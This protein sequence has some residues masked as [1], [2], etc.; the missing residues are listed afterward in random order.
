[1]N[2][3]YLKAAVVF[4]FMAMNSFGFSALAEEKTEEKVVKESENAAIVNGVVIS[5]SEFDR[6]L[7]QYQQRFTMQGQMLDGDQLEE[8]KDTILDT[9]IGRELLFQE[10]KKIN[11]KIE[12]QA[13]EDELSNM[14]KMFPDETAF[15]AALS[16]MGFSEQTIKSQIEKGLMVQKLVDKEYSEKIIISDKESKEFFDTHPEMFRQPEQV[17]ASHIL[18]KTDAGADK[19]QKDAAHKKIQSVQKQVKEGKEFADLAKEFS[20]CPS[21]DQGGDLGYFKRGDM[22]KPFEDAAFATDPGVVTDIVE[23]NFGYHLIKVTDKKTE[24]TMPFDSVKEKLNQYLKNEK[25]Q[26]E[27]DEYVK[28]LKAKAAIEKLI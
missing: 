19:E 25:L 7:N 1:M 26:K 27:L 4:L 5:R 2:V 3:G 17:K 20:D 12:P 6:E 14:R 23:T 16:Q 11:I 24:Q 9:L 15:T 28:K 13:I 21:K 18:V 8:V 10:S 22:V